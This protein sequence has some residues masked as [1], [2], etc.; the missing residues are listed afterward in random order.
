LRKNKTLSERSEF[1]LFPN[2]E[3][4]RSANGQGLAFFV[5][6]FGN[7]K[8]KG[9]KHFKIIHHSSS[10]HRDA[11]TGYPYFENCKKNE[12]LSEQGRALTPE[13]TAELSE[14]KQSSGLF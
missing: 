10:G 3:N 7:E 2:W 12:T 11:Q 1:V 6:F 14:A 8:K 13:A 9:L 5:S 4:S